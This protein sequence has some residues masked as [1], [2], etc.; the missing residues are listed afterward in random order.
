[1]ID[2]PIFMEMSSL[3][4][5]FFFATLPDFLSMKQ[6]QLEFRSAGEGCVDQGR[7]LKA[8][9]YSQIGW[10]KVIFA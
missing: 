10:K 4:P 9:D 8:R 5:T 7:L 1:M 3:S 6:K 2:C